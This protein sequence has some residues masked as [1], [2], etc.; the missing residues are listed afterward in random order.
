MNGLSPLGW[1][2]YFFAALLLGHLGAVR[3]GVSPLSLHRGFV[4]LA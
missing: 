4:G 2:S 3:C 1:Q